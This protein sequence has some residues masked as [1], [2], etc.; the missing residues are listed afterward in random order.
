[1]GS[2]VSTPDIYKDLYLSEKR[3]KEFYAA[4]YARDH[5]PQQVY[6]YHLT[7]YWENNWGTAQNPIVIE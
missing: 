3:A 4:A 6:Y 5:P 2:S 1:M 7:P